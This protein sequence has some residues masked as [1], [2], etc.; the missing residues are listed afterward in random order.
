MR[1]DDTVNDTQQA[2]SGRCSAVPRSMNLVFAGR[3]YP[4]RKNEIPGRLFSD[5]ESGESE[6]PEL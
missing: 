4:I 2:S 3:L 6:S 1:V 5:S